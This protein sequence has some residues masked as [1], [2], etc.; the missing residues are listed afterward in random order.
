MKIIRVGVIGCGTRLMT[1]TKEL[2]SEK[3]VF[4]AGAWDP[5]QKNAQA[6]LRAA[7]NYGGM[8]Y[9][10]LEALLNDTSLDWIMV[11]SPNVFHKDQIIAAFEHGKHVFSEKPLAITIED[12]VAINAAHKKSGKQ[13][14]TGFVLRYSP[15]Y[16]KV[17]EI[18]D[19]EIMGKIVSIDANENIPP[20]HGAYIAADWRRHRE[21][22]G[23][24]ILEK[25]VHDL[26]LFNWFTG[27]VPL[28]VAAFGGNNYFILE[29][30]TN[31]DQHRPTYTTWFES[32]RL[33][34]ETNPFTS[35]KTIEDNIVCILEFANRARVQ[36]QATMAN[37]I[38]ERRMYFHCTRGNLIVDLYTMKIIVKTIDGPVAS[39]FDF[40]K[41]ANHGGGD[42]VIAQEL[43]ESMKTG[44]KPKCGGKE[45]LRSTVVALAIDEARIQGKVVDLAPLWIQLS[46][47]TPDKSAPYGVRVNQA[48]E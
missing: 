8:I 3:Q 16:R 2:A 32:G 29:N 46:V 30:A 39:V 21:I 11:G 28:R 22:A 25:C 24:H 18:I 10:S 31:F 36:F 43:A 27:S 5:N 42:A 38:P 19:S 7:D 34:P 9:D 48:G 33:P 45:G 1:I 4:I 23:P 44:E 41:S 40:E 47:A 20:Y 15:L 12:C 26:D 13:F 35:D 37:P 17:K 6:L 14:A